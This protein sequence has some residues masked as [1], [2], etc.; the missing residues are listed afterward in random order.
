[1]TAVRFSLLGPLR[2]DRHGRTVCVPGGKIRALLA[3][4][5]LRPDQVVPLGLRTERLWGH[6]PPR[7]P[8]R[9]LLNGAARE[10]RREQGDRPA[11]APAFGALLRTWRK[12]ARLTQ[13]QLADR[14]GLNVR[15]VRRWEG[16]A[17]PR[18]S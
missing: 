8:R 17:T 1:M 13:E 18:D 10:P 3:T 9:A 4:L 5:L 2:G 7:R 16:G 11:E 6:R 15:T 12:R 14:A